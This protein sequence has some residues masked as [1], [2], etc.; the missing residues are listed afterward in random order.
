M[1][2]FSIDPENLNSSPEAPEP[3]WGFLPETEVE[4]SELHDLVQAFVAGLPDR[5]LRVYRARF[6][7]KLEQ[8]D[9]ASQ[10]G[11]TSS[12]VKTCEAR[13]RKRFFAYLQEHGYLED[14]RLLKRGFVTRLRSKAK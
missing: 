5:D 4:A 8:A 2:E 12:Q 11:L 3:S 13:I 6:E 14:Y 7:D 10:A 1:L 9:V